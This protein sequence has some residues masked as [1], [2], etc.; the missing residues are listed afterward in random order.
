MDFRKY[1]ESSFERQKRQEAF[2]TDEEEDIKLPSS[3]L[4]SSFET[5]TG[6]SPPPPSNS[7][8]TGKAAAKNSKKTTGEKAKAN[9][10][11]RRKSAS[12]SSNNKN[13]NS[14]ATKNLNGSEVTNASAS[15]KKSQANSSE[16]SKIT[17]VVVAHTKPNILKREL[18]S[19]KIPKPKI[20][21]AEASAAAAE[22]SPPKNAVSSGGEAKMS[23]TAKNS[24]VIA[25]TKK[26]AS[27]EETSGG[28]V[29]ASAVPPPLNGSAASNRNTI[30]R[31][32][33]S[34][35]TSRSGH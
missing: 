18:P 4:W 34:L 9:K 20:E 11:N 5:I 21:T 32:K 14:S 35:A 33:K 7:N 26:E 30:E 25:F 6:D 19:Y 24:W 16:N 28:A 8:D 29:A 1:K 17:E 13:A 3:E 12:K 27:K 10:T 22:I 23:E 15:E 2:T 31:L